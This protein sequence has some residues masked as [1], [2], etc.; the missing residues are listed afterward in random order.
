MKHHACLTNVDLIPTFSTLD[1]I[2]Q[3]G[4]FTST[5]IHRTMLLPIDIKNPS[6]N[7]HLTA[8][9]PSPI[10]TRRLLVLLLPPPKLGVYEHVA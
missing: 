3:I 6:L 1:G 10:A 7:Q 5:S 4:G 8:L 2:N 9:T